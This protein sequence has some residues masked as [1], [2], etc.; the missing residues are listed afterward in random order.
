[1]KKKIKS[2][3]LSAIFLGLLA[4][5]GGVIVMPTLSASNQ[6]MQKSIRTIGQSPERFL[7]TENLGLRG[8]F[9]YASDK[10][11][12]NLSVEETTNMSVNEGA[13]NAAIEEGNYEAWK[14]ALQNLNGFTKN[15]NIISEED[16][17]VLVALNKSESEEKNNSE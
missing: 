17:N 6:Q 8:E 10:S 2:K 1:M 5:S 14:E 4:I 3:F 7:Q 13:L 12:V 11:N 9:Q 16:F 15:G